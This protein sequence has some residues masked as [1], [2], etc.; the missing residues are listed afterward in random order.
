MDE[1]TT[2][3]PKRAEVERPISYSMANIDQET[4]QILLDDKIATGG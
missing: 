1:T 3:E 4:V 2:S